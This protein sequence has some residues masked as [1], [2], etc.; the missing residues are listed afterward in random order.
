[1]LLTRTVYVRGGIGLLSVRTSLAAGKHCILANKAP[2][3]L[4]Y[5][6]LMALSIKHGGA[7]RFSA[8]VCG[9]LPVINIG[10]RDMV[11]SVIK[12]VAQFFAQGH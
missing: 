7:L 5:G 1:M 9:G 4:D 6:G 8:T 12:C 2:L 10:Q 11:G 3:V